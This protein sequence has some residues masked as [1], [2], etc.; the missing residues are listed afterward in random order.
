[1]IEPTV[2][3]IQN[4]CSCIPLAQAINGMNDLV[5]LWNLPSTMYQNPFCSI[6]LPSIRC[7]V[8]P[9]PIQ[10]PYFSM[11]LCPYHFH[12][13]YPRQLPS[14]A[15]IIASTT[16]PMICVFHQNPPTRI[17]TF[18]P[19]T[20]V[21]M[22][23]SDSIQALENAIRQFQF[24]RVW[25]SCQIHS[26]PD[27]IH[28]GFAKVSTSSPSDSMVKNIVITLARNIANCLSRSIYRQYGKRGEVQKITL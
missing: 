22:I 25:M 20:R 3:Y 4:F 8:C 18:I 28:S 1:M 21:P 9:S 12:V 19:G 24:P 13:Q 23:G 17:I 10:S 27:L 26:I 2:L 7:S 11:I 16:V 5:K 6:C 14:I 15:P